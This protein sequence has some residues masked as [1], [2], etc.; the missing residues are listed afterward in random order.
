MSSDASPAPEAAAEPASA[1]GEAPDSPAF[2]APP[3]AAAAAAPNSV[4]RHDTSSSVGVSVSAPSSTGAA[5]PST[6]PNTPALSS[7]YANP[8]IPPTP[9]EFSGAMSSSPF[10]RN[11]ALALDS[12]AREL[13][14]LS[15]APT[16][17]PP[18]SERTSTTDAGAA[19]GSTPAPHAPSG[20]VTAAESVLARTSAGQ[21]A[22]REGVLP[23]AKALGAV[24]QPGPPPPGAPSPDGAPQST[25][26][27]PG[28]STRA[29][30]PAQP[31]QAPRRDISGA[32]TA[33]AASGSAAAAAAAAAPAPAPKRPSLEPP[34][35]QKKSVFGKLFGDKNS[36]SVSLAP[37]SGG[38]EAMERSAGSSTDGGAGAH[39][40]S[41]SAG[42]GAGALLARRPSGGVGA[43][44]KREDKER[45]KRE[46]AERK[47]RDK[48]DKEARKEAEKE[49]QRAR[50]ASRQRTPSQQG[51]ARSNDGKSDGH[52]H[53]GAG[54]GGAGDAS[55]SHKEKEGGVMDFMR[56]KVQ[57]KTSVTSRRSDDG[58]SDGEGAGGGGAKSQF[59][60]SERSRGG[61]SNASLTKKYGVCDKVIVG[62]GATAVVRLAHK[63][64][65]STEKLYAVKVG[66]A[67]SRFLSAMRDDFADPAPFAPLCAGVPQA[68]QERD[69]E[70][71]RQE[72]HER[73]LHLVDPAPVRLS[74]F[75]S[76][77]LIARR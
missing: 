2:L 58:R 5:T 34:P 47:E 77:R 15:L 53:H 4:Q 44:K 56:I 66:A 70:G 8:S 31:Q 29:S 41:S 35:Q 48:R 59:G 72:A 40:G 74:R 71:V 33:S 16:P 51:R 65:R 21:Q 13:G 37:S 39:A 12:P 9:S 38:G 24:P 43:D 73:V 57:R 23:G 60:G 50:S 68:P 1:P 11:P 46:K 55:S 14:N 3:A 20:P 52:H 26:A 49:Q 32:S 62:K 22:L 54:G 7:Q 67:C 76:C 69:R 10:V 45:E 25:L 63:W 75:F 64:D 17:S 61:Q 42:G 36:S 18:L 6:V 19:S 30:T 28:D 27:T